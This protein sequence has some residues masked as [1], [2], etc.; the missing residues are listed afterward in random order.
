ML[1]PGKIFGREPAM[2]LAFFGSV[3][4]VFST[5]VFPLTPDQQGALNAVAMAVVGILTAWMVAVDGGLALVVGLAKAVIALAISFGLQ[6]TPE[7]QVIVMTFVTVTAQLF[8]RTQVVA[9]VT[10]EGDTVPNPAGTS[11]SKRKSK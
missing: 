11:G 10:V 7:V 6:W 4:M 1:T 9:P 3:V 5:F 2:V 8:V